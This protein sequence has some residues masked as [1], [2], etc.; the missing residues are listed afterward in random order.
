ML[1]GTYCVILDRTWVTFPGLLPAS[2]RLES[3][4]LQMDFNSILLPG[5]C[6]ATDLKASFS[7][8]PLVCDP[9][10]WPG[11]GRVFSCP[12]PSWSRFLPGLLF[13]L[14]VLFLLIPDNHPRLAPSFSVRSVTYGTPQCS[15]FGII[16]PGHAEP[17]AWVGCVQ[18]KN[19]PVSPPCDLHVGSRLTFS[20]V[21]IRLYDTP[22]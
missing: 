16:K 18:T 14:S 7:L 17:R 4:I 13:W 20:G 2:I 5:S 19:S 21:G 6:Q 9:A 12:C 10:E 3:L 8:F 1:S 11:D 22:L 15:W